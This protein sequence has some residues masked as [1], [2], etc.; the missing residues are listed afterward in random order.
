MPSKRPQTVNSRRKTVPENGNGR[1]AYFDLTK[2]TLPIITAVTLI[3]GAIALAYQA[4]GFT[5]AYTAFQHETVAKIAAMEQQLINI[6]NA[7]EQMRTE[8]QG[9]KK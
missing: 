7:I 1:G 3:V 6:S 9:R 4:G 5:A 2:G 8:Q